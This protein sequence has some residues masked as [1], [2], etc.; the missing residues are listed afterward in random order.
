MTP[1][2]IQVHLRLVI[3]RRLT[4]QDTPLYQLVPRFFS[5]HGE[6]VYVQQRLLQLS[7]AL[8]I[9]IEGIVSESAFEAFLLD[10]PHVDKI[11]VLAERAAVSQAVAVA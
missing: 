3:P 4:A 6:R 5:K 9:V 8:P 10:F 2:T 11:V 7:S 1:D